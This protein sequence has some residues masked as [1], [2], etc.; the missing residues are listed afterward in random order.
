[1]PKDRPELRHLMHQNSE[2]TS[3][4]LPCKGAV[5]QLIDLEHAWSRKPKTK[6]RREVEAKTPSFGQK[7]AE[8]A[9]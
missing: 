5:G 6:V 1:M 8:N 9:G 4:S 7:G 2:P 3:S